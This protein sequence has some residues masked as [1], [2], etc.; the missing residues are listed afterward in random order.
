MN[1]EQLYRGQIGN[2]LR[3]RSADYFKMDLLPAKGQVP[4][5]DRHPLRR[6]LNAVPSMESFETN[7]NMCAALWKLM[8]RD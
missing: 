6:S 3:T 5:C 7:A 1:T 8:A 2:T 4:A